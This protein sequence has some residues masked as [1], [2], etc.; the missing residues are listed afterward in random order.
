MSK[1]KQHDWMQRCWEE[2]TKQPL[3]LHVRHQNNNQG[4][5]TQSSRIQLTFHCVCHTRADKVVH[6]QAAQAT[7]Q[8]SRLGLC[9]DQWENKYVH[10]FIQPPGPHSLWLWCVCIWKAGRCCWCSTCWGIQDTQPDLSSAV[11]SDP[12]ACHW[13]TGRWTPEIH[14]HT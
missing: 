1:A 4:C 8:N 9:P 5:I 11:T 14:T 2:I 12:Q 13:W 6:K 7:I 3:L 10:L